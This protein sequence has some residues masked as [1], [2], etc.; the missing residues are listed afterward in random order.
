MARLHRDA[1]LQVE[2]LE[3]RTLPSGM[4]LQSLFPAPQLAAA[5]QAEA[6]CEALPAASGP[7][8]CAPALPEWQLALLHAYAQSAVELV[9]RPGWGVAVRDIYRAFLDG[10]SDLRAYA[11]GDE[12]VEGSPEAIGFRA[13]PTTLRVTRQLHDAA[14]AAFTQRLAEPPPGGI[15]CGSLPADKPQVLPIRRSNLDGLLTD[16]E[17]RPHEVALEYKNVGEIPGIMAGGLSDSLG[18]GF[19]DRRLDGNLVV[20]RR[21]EQ[22]VTAALELRTEATVWV[23]DSIDFCPGGLGDGLAQLLTRPLQLLQA[24]ARAYAVPFTVTFA[25]E[26]EV[27]TLAGDE[28]PP[29]CQGT[30]PRGGPNSLLAM[31]LQALSVIQFLHVPFASPAAVVKFSAPPSS[32]T[33]PAGSKVGHGLG[34]AQPGAK[35][36]SSAQDDQIPLGRIPSGAWVLS[37][38]ATA[39]AGQEI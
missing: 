10:P 1:R 7:K 31:N 35:A 38:E 37:V 33:L 39:F 32:E 2:A 11:K 8:P 13:S 6:E 36:A 9:L 22:G 24:N 34:A 14:R 25:S 15:D 12:V 3:T 18:V 21:T 27:T 16:E 26:P 17:L 23:Y 19:D 20:T 28:L 29:S 4:P 5:L 30:G